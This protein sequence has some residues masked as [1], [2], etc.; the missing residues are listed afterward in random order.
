MTMGENRNTY[1]GQKDP[2]EESNRCQFHSNFFF[3][4]SPVENQ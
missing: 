4:F 1:H 2:W 3:F